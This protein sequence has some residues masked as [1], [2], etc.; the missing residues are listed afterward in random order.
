M[1]APGG[2]ACVDAAVGGTTAAAL[3]EA[4]CAA[5]A[6]AAAKAARCA[7]RTAF[8]GVV[9]ARAGEHAP[10]AAFVSSIWGAGA[11]A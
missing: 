7:H 8:D 11:S 1:S 6:D 4:D 10:R 3:Q 2:D 5:E 9:V